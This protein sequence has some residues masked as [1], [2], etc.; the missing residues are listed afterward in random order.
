[1]LVHANFA[2][3]PSIVQREQLGPI[4]GGVLDLGLSSDQLD[5]HDR[6]FSFTADGELDLRFDT[7]GGEPA[8]RLL[9]RLSERDIADLIYAYGEE[10]F[11]RRIARRIVEARK[12]EPV[13]TAAQLAEIARASYPR[14]RNERIN[15]ATRTFQATTDRRQS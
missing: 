14:Q 13:R 6:G 12:T 11:S 8:W 4:D 10:R 9:S 2:E 1:M 5:D 15:P 3:L 7:N